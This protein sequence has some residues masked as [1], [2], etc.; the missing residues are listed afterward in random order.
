MIGNINLNPETSDVSELGYNYKNES[1]SFNSTLYH[2]KYH[3]K[4][5]RNSQSYQFESGIFLDNTSVYQNGNTIASTGLESELKYQTKTGLSAFLNFNWLDG[6]KGDKVNSSYNFK[7]VPKITSALG[8]S[9]TFD[10]YN[11]SILMNYR[12]KT[13]DAFKNIDSSITLDINLSYQQQFS[14][15][16]LNHNLKFE[17]ITNETPQVAEYVRRNGA[18]PLK[19]EL[20]TRIY[21]QVEFIF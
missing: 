14:A 3:N 15:M 19:L 16:K 13:Q 12:D 6:D 1:F 20:E 9:K 21:Y 5:F 10:A 18:E 7:Y 8:I 4:I 17:N 2:A 11:T